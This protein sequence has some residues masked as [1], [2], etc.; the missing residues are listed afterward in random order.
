MPVDGWGSVDAG[1]SRTVMGTD[2]GPAMSDISGPPPR[3]GGQPATSTHSAS[4]AAWPLERHA[5][6]ATWGKGEGGGG[7]RVGWGRAA[8]L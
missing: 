6:P 5:G 3:G 8:E 7:V 1:G 2:I 4:S